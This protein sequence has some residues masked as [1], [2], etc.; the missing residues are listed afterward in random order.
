M[1]QKAVIK[2]RTNLWI[3][4]IVW[5]LAAAAALT[6]MI[7]LLLCTLRWLDRIDPERQYSLNALEQNAENRDAESVAL[8]IESEP[9]RIAGLQR[10]GR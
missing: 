6:M 3:E 1:Q 10:S 8:G 9:T 7:A 2:G 4:R 5:N